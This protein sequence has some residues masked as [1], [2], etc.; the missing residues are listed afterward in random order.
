[1]NGCLL[2]AVIEGKKL[3]PVVVE[4]VQDVRFEEVH[5]GESASAG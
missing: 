4:R 1:M 2:L 5:D 3:V